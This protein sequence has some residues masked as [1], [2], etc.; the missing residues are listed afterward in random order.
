MYRHRG[1][2]QLPPLYLKYRDQLTCLRIVNVQQASYDLNIKEAG[3][4][5][6]LLQESGQGWQR[7]SDL[8][9]DL[10]RVVGLIERDL[11]VG[12]DCNMVLEFWNE[13][14]LHL[15]RYMTSCLI[16]IYL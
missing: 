6:V 8:V 9:V 14:H 15:L 13:I 2:H 7:D 11:D 16:C 10:R 3:P 1:Y 4:L 5:L 12:C